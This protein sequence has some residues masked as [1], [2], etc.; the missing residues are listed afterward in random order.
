MAGRRPRRPRPKQRV[1]V[2]ME[3]V[4]EKASWM[5][6]TQGYHRTR[7]Q[8]I[9]ESFG[10]SH[11]ALYYHFES[12]RDILTQLSLRSIEHL[13]TTAR[14]K[15]AEPGTPGTRLMSILTAHADYL[16][17]STAHVATLVEQETEIPAEDFAII[18]GLRR[19]Y[20]DMLENLYRMGVR[21]GELPDVDPTIATSLLLGACNWIGRWYEP[22]QP[23]GDDQVVAQASTFLSAILRSPTS[24]T[25]AAE[26]ADSVRSQP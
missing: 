17:G 12:K 19:E 1:P 4:L 11:A 3:D 25:T 18:Q 6:R 5:F 9:A 13:L 16:V 7:M 23:L 2:V 24:T 21:G 8:D 22:S 10:V 20:I 15:V 14:E 26:D